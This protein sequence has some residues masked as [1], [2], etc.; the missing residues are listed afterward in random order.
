MRGQIVGWRFYGEPF[1]VN[2]VCLSAVE[3]ALRGEYIC[4][5]PQ[6]TIQ[7]ALLKG[8]AVTVAQVVEFEQIAGVYIITKVFLGDQ[9]E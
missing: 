4:V 8:S 9:K 2:R 7:E 1:G 5:L 3:A 6:R